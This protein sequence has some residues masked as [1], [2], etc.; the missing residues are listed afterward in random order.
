[1]APLPTAL[2]L[3]LLP[4]AGAQAQESDDYA[5]MLGWLAD[6]RIDERAFIGANGAIA[7]NLSAGDL[8]RQ[9]NLRAFAS[10]DVARASVA[11]RQPQA[12][13]TFDAPA[14]AAA[15]IGGQAFGGASGLLSINQASGSGNA[16]LNAIAATLAQ[17]G[18]REASDAQ[19]SSPALA[20]AGL[21]SRSGQGETQT[22]DRKAAVEATAL[23]G[24]EGVLQLNQ[25]AGSGNA[26]D[27]RLVLS[28]QTVP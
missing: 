7:V 2:L 17:Q 27:N 24:F 13:D 1:M 6:T 25:I 23:R 22:T 11:A 5:A 9:G 26:T 21:Q 19:L 18:I 12:A 4:L 28:V 10:G 3:V 20:S 14:Q 8:N 16:E 15:V